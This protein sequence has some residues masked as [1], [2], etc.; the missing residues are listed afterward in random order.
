MKIVV[1]AMGGDFAPG[2]ILK[3]TV[4]AVAE[5]GV[6]AILVGRRQQIEDGLATLGCRD[7]RISLLHAEQVV[8]M[9]ESP[10]VVARNKRDSS[11]SVGLGLV[12]EGKAN[13]FVSA[14]NTGAVMATALF[15][16]GR[17]KGIER[18]TLG[19]VLPTKTGKAIIA[20]IGANVDC[21]PSYLS[22]FAMMGSLYMSKVFDIDNPRVGL[23]NIGEEESKGNQM[24]SE[25]YDLLKKSKVNFVGNVE[26]K[27]VPSGIA[28][29]VVCDGFVGNVAIKLTE[30]LADFIFAIIKDELASGWRSKLLALGL[31]PNLRRIRDRLDY[32]GF[33]GAT[34]LGV[35]GVCIIAHGRS[36]AKAIRHAIR[37]AR[38]AAQEDIV[39]AIKNGVQTGGV[40]AFV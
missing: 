11:I 16:L 26:G 12:R 7:P 36:N 10:S 21:K 9:H 17:I 37:V 35:D 39:E 19:I 31:L 29:V 3:G 1:D 25:A 28:D 13:A 23:L 22:Q 5:Y 34:L 6:E 4:E 38:Q 18:P 14:G 30:G 32:A 15:T 27:D 24:V 33:G 2:E 20:D 8:E 40:N